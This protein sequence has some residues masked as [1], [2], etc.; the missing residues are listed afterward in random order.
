MNFNILRNWSIRPTF[1]RLAL[2]DFMFYFEETININKSFAFSSGEIYILRTL[3]GW[4]GGGIEIRING[5]YDK[6]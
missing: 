1:P 5:E 4:G 3:R 2:H 6:G